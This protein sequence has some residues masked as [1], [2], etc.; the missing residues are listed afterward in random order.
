M[1]PILIRSQK[2]YSAKYSFA[3]SEN[4]NTNPLISLF[5]NSIE[6]ELIANEKISRITAFMTEKNI[7][8]VAVKNSGPTV[9][10]FDIQNNIVTLNNIKDTCF[11]Y[12]LVEFKKITKDTIVNNY[13]CDVFINKNKDILYISKQLPFYINPF[14]LNS[15]AIKYG[16]VKAELIGS[17]TY[18]LKK[19]SI[20][21]SQ[22]NITRPVTRVALKMKNPFF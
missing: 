19:I 22:K 6:Y 12:T 1:N 15:N 14:Y 2:T 18:I 21:K 10:I 4:G 13:K 3:N 11:I 8:G 17:G 5:L 20:I 16:I 9:S 7:S